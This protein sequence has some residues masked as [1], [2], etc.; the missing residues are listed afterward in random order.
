MKTNVLSTRWR[1]LAGP[2]ITGVLLVLLPGTLLGQE[3]PP[4]YGN[5][6]TPSGYGDPPRP[7]S[8]GQRQQRRD[9]VD[10]RAPE[11]RPATALLERMG[12]QLGQAEWG[13]LI[14]QLQNLLDRDEGSVVRIGPGRF[15]PLRVAANNILKQM[16][17]ASRKRYLQQFEAVAERS[18]EEALAQNN[19][20]ALADV[21]T[22][23]QLTRAG[24]RAARAIALR[25]ADRG[26]FALALHWYEQAGSDRAAAGIRE[27][28]KA[29]GRQ[30]VDANRL[31]DWPMLMGS[32][33]RRA[34]ATARLP[35]LV[36]IWRQPLLKE[37][38][39]ATNL[40]RVIRNVLDTQ[41]GVIPSALPIVVAGKVA[42]RTISGVS[43][44]DSASGKLLWRTQ[45][46]SST[47][48]TPSI[49]AVRSLSSR[50][51]PV[52]DERIQDFIFRDGVH[53]LLSSDGTRLFV[54]EQQV[55]PRQSY[56]ASRLRSSVV[57]RVPAATNALAA[58]NLAAGAI[59]W[60]VGGPESSESFKPTL[61]GHY[62]HGVPAVLRDELF[63]VTER[64]NTIRLHVL[65]AVTGEAKWSRLLAF[66][67]T[68]VERDH[69]R[70]L[71]TAQVTVSDGIILCPTTAD[72]LVA[73]DPLTR[74]ILWVQRHKQLGA[75]QDRDIRRLRAMPPL[76]AQWPASAPIVVGDIVVCTPPE[77][78]RI[79]ALNLTNGKR[80]WSVPK[81]TRSY[82]AGATDSAVVLVSRS[83][84]AAITA[85]DGRSEWSMSWPDESFPTGRGVQSGN[86]LHQPLSSGQ[87]VSVNLNDGEI[88][89]R[90]ASAHASQTMGNLV[91]HAGG[92]LIQTPE[93]IE[94]YDLRPTEP[95]EPRTLASAIKAAQLALADRN[96]DKAI[97]ALDQ[98]APD[99]VPEPLQA[100]RNSILRAALLERARANSPS[101]SND[102]RR[103]TE[104]NEDAGVLARLED[105]SANGGRRLLR[106]L[107][108]TGCDVRKGRARAGDS[109]S[110]VPRQPRPLAA[111]Q[112]V[113]SL[114]QTRRTGSRRA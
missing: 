61:S 41:P 49:V 45:R 76:S 44:F 40:R 28:N 42:C 83:H 86:F 88:Q 70:R 65:D 77:S 95:E 51:R 102:L 52:G 58:Y 62:F 43:V 97:A 98:F 99:D 54:V 60:R 75:S 93:S 46:E 27:L 101:A 67:D 23:Y 109:G 110:R 114:D 63:V 100:R 15:V 13:T 4:G 84:V 7:G 71:L 108:A 16:P 10:S 39:A 80:L 94:A 37:G 2:V 47:V 14:P 104:L 59:E 91:L 3:P 9:S 6:G 38:P 30:Q 33:D 111:G 8:Q 1:A 55:M 36:P 113:R 68:P 92:T 64:D 34:S 50:A 69:V 78:T 89:H 74:N 29:V 72:W 18:L 79:E 90:T 19:Y 11:N 25:H 112:T 81:K 5:E 107:S 22:R 12:T 57:E 85:S 17:E 32:A 106:S 26:E 73:V 31:D 56:A 105:R 96:P 103:L 48:N 24:K 53:G 87:I 82:V 35:M 20:P 21:A 66:V